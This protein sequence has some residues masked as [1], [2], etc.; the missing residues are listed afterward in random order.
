MA[1]LIQDNNHL[2]ERLDSYGSRLYKL[3]NLNIPQQT[4]QFLTDL[5]KAR[6]KKKRR[7]DS[8]KTPP[9][10]LPHYPP[11]PP[12]LAD[13]RNDHIPKVNLMQ[14][15]WKSLYEEDKPATPEPTWSIPSSDLAIE[16]ECKYDIAAMYGISHWWFQRQRFYIDRHTSEGDRKSLQTYML[17]ISVVRIEVLS[18]YGYNYMKKIVLRRADL[19]E[20]IIAKRDFKYLYPVIESPRAA[21]FKDKYGVQM[22]IQ[23]NEIHK[24]SD[25][26]LPQIDEALDYLVKEF[27]KHLLLSDIED[28]VMDPVTHKFNP[29]LPLKSAPA[30]DHLNQNE[31]LSLEPRDHLKI[32]LRHYSIMLASSCTVKSKIDIKSPTHYPYGIARTFE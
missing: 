27:K 3:E 16:E 15:W 29:P 24:F 23:F 21:T 8:P 13:I 25:G 19:K 17:I 5:A 12:P 26:T 31:L 28:S 9:V 14:D 18:L 4:D 1:N 30:F 2:E 11:T 6:R 20:Y 7:H 10:S 32:S 22:I